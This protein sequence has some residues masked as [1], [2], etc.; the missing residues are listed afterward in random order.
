MTGFFQ[1]PVGRVER[2]A[3]R[4]QKRI[5][6]YRSVRVEG[7]GRGVVSHAWAALLVETVRRRRL[8]TSMSAA[9]APWRKPRAAPDR[10]KILLDVALTVAL[11]RDCLSDVRMLRR[12]PDVFRTVASDPI[13][14]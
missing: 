7:G 11:R 10:G 13:I 3:S 6:C 1:R 5:G 8:D 4:V 14:S 9:L 12:E 2:S